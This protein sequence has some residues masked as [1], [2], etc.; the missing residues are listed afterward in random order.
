MKQLRVVLIALALTIIGVEGI[1]RLDPLGMIY[2]PEIL[3]TFAQSEPFPG[4]WQMTVGIHRFTHWS[5]TVTPNYTRL[6][7]DTTSDADETWVFLGD[8]VTFGYGVNDDVPFANQIARARPDVHVINAA[9]I[10]YGS[11]NVRDRA[12]DF[13][14]A[15]RLIYLI[16]GNDAEPRTELPHAEVQMP[17][18]GINLY[19]SY[20]SRYLYL[21]NDA[22]RGEVYLATMDLPRFCDDVRTLD[23]D[24]RVTL[25]IFEG[26]VLQPQAQ[27]C[28][29]VVALSSYLPQTVSALDDHPNAAGHRFLAEQILAE[30]ERS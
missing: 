5:A 22:P 14:D 1:L 24:P 25:F 8:S 20:W 4:G 18:S 26:S 30:I 27:A 23:G 10:G 16:Y 29:S 17:V 7:P 13:P 11:A 12:A 21:R 2:L 6:V 3:M 9:S 15:D 19:I 28:G